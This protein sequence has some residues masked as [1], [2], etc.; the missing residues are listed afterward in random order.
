MSP[1]LERTLKF[2]LTSLLVLSTGNTQA[3]AS[4]SP[5]TPTKLPPLKTD[6]SFL[7]VGKTFNFPN[8]TQ[9]SF[10]DAS[11]TVII[12]PD[13]F[14]H[15]TVNS[16]IGDNIPDMSHGGMISTIIQTDPKM[17]AHIANGKVDVV[18]INTGSNPTDVLKILNAIP[19]NYKSDIVL[20]LSIGTTGDEKE[21]RTVVERIREL[22]SA[23]H[24][25]GTLNVFVAQGNTGVLE[26]RNALAA[27]LRDIPTVTTVASSYDNIANPDKLPLS[28]SSSMRGFSTD[29]KPY[30]SVISVSPDGDING[31]GVPDLPKDFKAD[32]S[33][34]SQTFG[35]QDAKEFIGK[36]ADR[37]FSSKLLPKDTAPP[38]GA[39]YSLQ[40]LLD[41]KFTDLESIKMLT[42]HL[43][44][45]KYEEIFVDPKAIESFS[46]SIGDWSG[47]VFFERSPENKVQIYDGK[48]GVNHAH[49]GASTS[50]ATPVAVINSINAT[51]GQQDLHAPSSHTTQIDPLIIRQ[52]NEGMNRN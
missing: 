30:A 24:S 5:Q 15:P 2:T 27:M 19:N 47:V 6:P 26:G 48:H 21:W 8:A 52:L 31:D 51:I 11:K 49:I 44:N 37:V 9:Q 32:I 35:S 43:P 25:K 34:A 12:I 38:A 18:N 39:L 20:S 14:G 7:S 28:P 17:R 10:Q 41:S 46:T 23:P 29:Q 1:F 3:L 50:F 4:A 33:Y 45:P 22:S 40:N 16:N 36:D 42:Q 13:F